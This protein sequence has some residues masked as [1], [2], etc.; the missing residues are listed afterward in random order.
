MSDLMQYA[1]VSVADKTQTVVQIGR[2]YIAFDKGFDVHCPQQ[3]REGSRFTKSVGRGM[4][5]R[6]SICCPFSYYKSGGEQH[7]VSSIACRCCMI[8]PQQVL[9]VMQVG[10]T[11]LTCL[12]SLQDNLD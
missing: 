2:T 4:C 6:L 1:Q 8:M 10:N 5:G 12:Q 3:G 7:V 9:D 11:L